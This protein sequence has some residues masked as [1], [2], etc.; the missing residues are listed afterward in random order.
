VTPPDLGRRWLGEA[1]RIPAE[2]EDGNDSEGGSEKGDEDREKEP[3]ATLCR[4]C[5]YK[6]PLRAPAIEPTG[7]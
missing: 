2:E 1:Y 4:G 7:S 3:G 6:P 5:R